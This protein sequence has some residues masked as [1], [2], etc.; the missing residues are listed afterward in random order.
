[1]KNYYLLLREY[2]RFYGKYCIYFLII[3]GNFNLILLIYKPP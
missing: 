1:M 2:F 3:L